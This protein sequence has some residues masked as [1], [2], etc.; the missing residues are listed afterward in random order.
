MWERFTDLSDR[1]DVQI[2]MVAD[3]Q[4]RVSNSIEFNAANWYPSIK[5]QTYSMA[6]HRVRF[7]EV[8]KTDMKWS[9]FSVLF[10]LVYIWFHLR[11]LFLAVCGLSI[12]LMSFPVTQVLYKGVFRVDMF[13]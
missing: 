7:N 13:A 8:I 5:R 6:L 1:L 3:F 11:S 12:I 2:Q 9:V 10:V 4:L